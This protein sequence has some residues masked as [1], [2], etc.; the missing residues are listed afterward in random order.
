VSTRRQESRRLDRERSITLRS[1]SPHHREARHTTEDYHQPPEYSSTKPT[2]QAAPWW[3][4]Q[5][6]TTYTDPHDRPYYQEQSYNDKW[7]SWGKW[8]DY[9]KNSASSHQSH[10]VDY[11]Q[12]PPRHSTPHD[13]STKPLTAFSST[14]T[15]PP[16]HK[17]KK[18]AH[19]GDDHSTASVNVPS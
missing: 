17:Q 15:A 7:E 16:R 9:S 14:H 11:K 4:N 2:L 18:P 10:W 12:P 1:A 13:S 19:S 6:A 3:T 5:H 8:K